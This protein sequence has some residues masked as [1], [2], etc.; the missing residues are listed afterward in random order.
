MNFNEYRGVVWETDL[1]TIINEKDGEWPEIVYPVMG[2]V[3]EY[4]ELYQKM[5]L[6]VDPKLI[7]K[8]AGDLAWYYVSFLNRMVDNVIDEWVQPKDVGADFVWS[9][10]MINAT[11][12]FG[13]AA[14]D[15]RKLHRDGTDKLRE[16]RQNVIIGMAY[17]ITAVYQYLGEDE[18]D[19]DEII[20][21]NKKKLFK[22]KAQNQIKGDGDEREDD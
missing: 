13:L 4:A 16:I 17:T 11:I 21:M 12:H 18:F 1:L 15:S 6:G 3:G 5:V 14:G 2:I 9:A 20:E 8:E 7:K 19:W 10:N 22:R